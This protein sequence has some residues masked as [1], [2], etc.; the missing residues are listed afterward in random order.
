MYD[1]GNDDEPQD[2][3]E[4]ALA[5]ALALSMV[6]DANVEKVD[7]GGGEPPKA[8]AKP[9][10]EEEHPEVDI[11]ANFMKDVIGDLG[12]DMDADDL[13]NEAK[14]DNDKKDKKDE[15]NDKK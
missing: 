7:G 1:E 4:K 10:P 13:I 5:E 11:D 6:P 2:D 14:K 8:E 15:E 9:A 12:I 3:D